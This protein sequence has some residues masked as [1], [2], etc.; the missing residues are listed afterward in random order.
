MSEAERLIVYAE[1]RVK[2]RN[3]VDTVQVCRFYPNVYLGKP[4]LA[5]ACPWS[6]LV[7]LA[8]RL[9]GL[10]RPKKRSLRV[11]EGTYKRLAVYAA[12][13]ETLR[14]EAK[15]RELEEVVR[16]LDEYELFFWF[17]RFLAAFERGRVALRRPA[18]AFKVLHGLD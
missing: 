16:G 1:K 11:G 3:S 7:L 5:A 13:R 17:T 10:V 8:E 4:E 15:V 6:E 2:R 9:G 14:S 18:R 12:V